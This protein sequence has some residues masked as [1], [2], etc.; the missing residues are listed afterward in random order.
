MK[1]LICLLMAVLVTLA[2]VSCKKTDKTGNNNDSEIVMP[3]PAVITMAASEIE[4]N[5]A[6]LNARIGFS[7]A[8][9]DNVNY[10]FFWGTGEDVEG[11]YSPGEGALDENN[12]Y[13]A[14]IMG[15]TPETDYWFKAFVEIDGKSY[16]G[17]IQNFMT[18]VIR[19]PDD[20]VDLGMVL[21]RGDGT[22]YTLYWAKSNLCETGLC[23]NPEDYGDYYAWGE[24][25]PKDDYSWSTY[26]FGTS[27]NGPFSKYN[28]KGS[29]GTVDN[30][31]ELDPGP[32]GDDVASKILGGNWRMPTRD[33]MTALK[34]QCTWAE[35]FINGVKVQRAT[36]PN[37]KNIYFPYAGSRYGATGLNNAGSYAYVWSSSLG[38]NFPCYACYLVFGQGNLDTIDYDRCNGL[39]VRP[40]WEE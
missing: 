20:V 17:G 31:T 21:S 16:S 32:E 12:T 40:V 18:G 9:R 29:F 5:S 4:A 26:Q 7:G 36:G 11:T 30:N 3:D 24:T 14:E 8:S 2:A 39:S 37:G 13:S 1:K 6:R 34:D 10:G 33:E 15:L 19:I 25:A 28:T 27:Q 23:A 38:T 22:T 35:D